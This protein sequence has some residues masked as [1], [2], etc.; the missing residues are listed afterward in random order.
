MVFTQFQYF[1]YTLEIQTTT[2]VLLPETAEIEQMGGKPIPTLYLLHGLSDDH[3]CWTRMTNVERY[4]R[5][6]YVAVVMPAVNRSFYTDMVHGAKYFTF[7][8]EEL[9]KVME[10]YFPLATSRAGRF[11]AGLSMGGYGAMKLGLRLPGRYAAVASF[12]GPLELQ[13]WYQF[14]PP[15]KHH[16]VDD[17]FGS[18]KQLRDGHDNLR[19]LA[20]E[21][22]PE[23][24]PR[25]YVSCGTEDTFIAANDQFVRDF[26]EKLSIEYRRVAGGHTWDVWDEQVKQM[27]EWLALEKLDGVW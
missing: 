13:E 7:V 11:A 25:M 16:Q 9:S 26:G 17:I 4:A 3:T 12:S 14:L 24:A 23:E 10:T 8:S 20:Q 2:Y 6:H 19:R 18:E 1:S 22:T 5:K 27:L 15:E 21:I